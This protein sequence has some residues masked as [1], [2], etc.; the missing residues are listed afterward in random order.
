MLCGESRAIPPYPVCSCLPASDDLYFPKQFVQTRISQSMS[1]ARNS[2]LEFTVSPSHYNVHYCTTQHLY[3]RTFTFS[4]FLGP[5]CLWGFCQNLKR[6]K[7]I[8]PCGCK[9]S[10]WEKLQSYIPGISQAVCGLLQKQPPPPHL[11]IIRAAY[12]RTPES[13]LADESSRTV[14]QNIWKIEHTMFVNWNLIKSSSHP[15]P[16]TPKSLNIRLHS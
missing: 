8:L 5:C 4:S 14:C 16:H 15:L 1:R 13:Y 9:R 11:V 7:W 2:V 12:L 6:I 3:Y 10:W